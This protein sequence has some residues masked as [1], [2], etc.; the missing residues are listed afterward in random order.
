MCVCVCV[1]VS[2]HP[3]CVLLVVV[4]TGGALFVGED[5]NFL[6]AVVT[7]LEVVLH[8]CT[9]KHKHAGSAVLVLLAFVSE[10]YFTVLASPGA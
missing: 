2:T 7:Q 6:T 3:G 10:L 8:L 9:Y 5:G 1:L 4:I